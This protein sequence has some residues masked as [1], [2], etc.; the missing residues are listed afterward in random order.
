MNHLS[1]LRLISPLRFSFHSFKHS[2]T[3]LRQGLSHNYV[4]FL[5]HFFLKTCWR[6]RTILNKKNISILYYYWAHSS[7]IFWSFLV[8]LREKKP[9]IQSAFLHPP[10]SARSV[11]PWSHPSSAFILANLTNQ[12]LWSSPIRETMI[13]GQS[14]IH[15]EPFTAYF[16][17]GLWHLTLLIILCMFCIFNIFY[18]DDTYTR[19]VTLLKYVSHWRIC[20][21]LCEHLHRL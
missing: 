4:H 2:G 17:W 12:G 11:A 8:K 19:T 9:A 3:L 21:K 13:N 5:S 7:H 6:F 18:W 14:P 1:C 15:R 16:F 10:P 20:T